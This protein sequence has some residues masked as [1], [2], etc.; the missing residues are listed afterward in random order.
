MK[1]LMA[2]SLAV[3][4]TFAM[5]ACGETSEDSNKK[6][7]KASA[8]MQEDV[9]KT[10][11]E[12]EIAS[13]AEESKAEVESENSEPTAES[14][15][16][17]ASGKDDSQSADITFDEFQ[18][19]ADDAANASTIDDAEKIILEK[20][21]VDLDSRNVSE[22]DYTEANNGWDWTYY[23]ISYTLKTP[24]NLFGDDNFGNPMPPVN[25][26][27]V[28]V[29]TTDKTQSPSSAMTPNNVQ[30]RM[31]DPYEQRKEYESNTDYNI[32]DRVSAVKSS[33][34][35]TFDAKY[36]ESDDGFKWHSAESACDINYSME[37]SEEVEHVVIF[38]YQK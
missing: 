11:V 32:L 12:E 16:N 2:I 15:T 7:S 24:L 3:C 26:I 5:T 19:I 9:S 8:S 20:L 13:S 37:S 33:L 38:D 1:K 10:D 28:A 36:G 6:E 14:E 23:G 18:A 22:Y 34:R 31:M 35:D 21:P 25:V 4:L 17:S 29:S 27:C 30:I